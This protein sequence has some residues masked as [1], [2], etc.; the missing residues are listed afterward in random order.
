MN[1]LWDPQKAVSSVSSVLKL[2]Q[3]VRI[4]QRE[5]LPYLACDVA[6][7]N[8]IGQSAEKVLLQSSHCLVASRYY[9]FLSF[10]SVSLCHIISSYSNTLF[11]GI[12]DAENIPNNMKTPFQLVI[13]LIYM[14]PCEIFLLSR[15]IIGTSKNLPNH[16]TGCK[17]FTHKCVSKSSSGRAELETALLLCT[18]LLFSLDA[19]L[20]LFRSL[21]VCVF[22]SQTHKPQSCSHT[23]LSLST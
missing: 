21:F 1:E 20:S 18:I 14:L 22:L 2:T 5:H 10:S 3:D 17:N 8:K 4:T 19:F 16:K 6:M 13:W 11:S 7:K 9:Y 12:L 15:P 23:F